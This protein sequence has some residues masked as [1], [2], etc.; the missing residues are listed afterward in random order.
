MYGENLYIY[1]NMMKT[2]ICILKVEIYFFVFYLFKN[3]SNLTFSSTKKNLTQP[4]RFFVK[5]VITVAKIQ[6]LNV[7]L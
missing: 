3:K 5:K 2:F 6:K 1:I 7:D 4:L